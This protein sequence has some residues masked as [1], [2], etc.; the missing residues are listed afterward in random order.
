MRAL[1]PYALLVVLLV[2]A[3]VAAAVVCSK[4]AK[5]A[6]AKLRS[7]AAPRQRQVD[8]V[9][10]WVDGTDPEWLRDKERVIE[11][12]STEVD[13]EQ[14]NSARR[15]ENYDELRYLLRSVD[16]YANDWVRHVFIVVADG[17]RPAYVDFDNNP[18]VRL[19]NHSEILYDCVLPTYNSVTIESRVFRIEGLSEHFLYMNDDTMFG[20]PLGLD[21]FYDKAGERIRVFCNR[22]KVDMREPRAEHCPYWSSIINAAKLV[23]GEVGHP[24]AHHVKMYDKRVQQRV[25]EKYP[26]EM[27]ALARNQ[28]R[29]QSD[30]N[31]NQL[32]AFYMLREEG[33]GGTIAFNE[34]DEWICLALVD[35]RTA[36]S[37]QFKL[38][39]RVRPKLVCFNDSTSHTYASVTVRILNNFR[40]MFPR[41][42]S[43]EVV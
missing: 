29:S 31:F 32:C 26:L 16:M 17:Q 19:V 1:W 4:P 39:D 42:S 10:L 30:V 5:A 25:F 9:I 22:A 15:F 21:Y 36:N 12:Y 14:S 3:A 28:F 13:S 18:R 37:M 8:L 24:V 27:R 7:G 6:V 40:R 35:H 11:S 34:N 43:F 38:V 20:A 41:P 23:G 2:S 33:G